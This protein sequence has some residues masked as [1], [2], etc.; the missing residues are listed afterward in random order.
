MQ[1]ETTNTEYIIRLDRD[2]FSPADIEQLLRRLRVQELTARL[3]GT[4]AEVEQLADEIMQQ[5]WQ[6][7]RA[8]P[9]PVQ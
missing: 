7:G 8:T 5:W 1:V 3:G 6:T 4:P 9:P 2:N